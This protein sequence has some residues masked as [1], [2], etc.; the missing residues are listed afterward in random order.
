MK[1]KRIAALMTDKNEIA[2]KEIEMVYPGDNEVLI[3]IEKIGICG[4]DI[5]YYTKGESA[6]GKIKYPHI[7]GHECAGTVVQ[8]GKNVIKLKTGDRVAVEPGKPCFKC[9]LCKSGK[10]N[11]CDDMIFMSTPNEDP[12][13]TGEGAFVEYS[14]RPAELCYKLDDGISFEEGAM[15]EP[16]SVALHAIEKADVKAGRS[17]LVLGTGPIGICIIMSLLANGCREIFSADLSEFRNEY[18]EKIGVRKSFNPLNDNYVHDIK[19][20]TDNKGVDMVFDTTCNEM[21]IQSAFDIVKKGGNIVFVGV[22]SRKDM[23]IDI[24]QMLKKEITVRSSFRYSNK[25]P[26][27][28]EL[29][30]NKLVDINKIITN[31]YKIHELSKALETAK[32][33]KD[34]VIKI[35]IEF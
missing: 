31:H 3:K 19:E 13:K 27:A 35:I 16:L 26:L 9:E 28:I 32:S 1:N 12:N 21:A 7:L 5:T 24:S 10:Y 6:I 18:S 17:A 29:I 4:S 8:T 20:M 33:N 30:K 15:I 23:P 34:N 14:V 25:Y 2:V 22:S 11:L